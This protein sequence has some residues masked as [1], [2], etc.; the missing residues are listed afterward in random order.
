LPWPSPW[1]DWPGRGEEVIELAHL[2]VVDSLATAQDACRA[3][4]AENGQAGEVVP[5]GVEQ[6][7]GY[8]AVT[9]R[10]EREVLLIARVN[11]GRKGKS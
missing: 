6:P 9:A 11:T 3:R 1:G 5:L 2:V 4:L 8:M 10:P 7:V